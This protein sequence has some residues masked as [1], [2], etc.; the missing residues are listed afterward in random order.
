MKIAIPVKFNKENPPIS[1]LF[2]HAKWFAFVEDE[3]VTIE[4]NPYDGGIAV[5]DWLLHRGVDTIVTQHIGQKPFMLLHKEGVKLYYPGDGRVLLN[6]AIEALKQGTLEEI[7]EE[8]VAQFAR[9]R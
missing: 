8:N 9:H 6:E 2:G 5:V 1:P 4:E 7:N 3:K